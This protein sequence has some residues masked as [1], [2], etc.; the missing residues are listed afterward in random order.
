MTPKEKE[1]IIIL[2][3]YLAVCKNDGDKF[4]IMRNY[5]HTKISNLLEYKRKQSL[6]VIS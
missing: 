2:S 5:L 6:K 4:S 3:K 1:S